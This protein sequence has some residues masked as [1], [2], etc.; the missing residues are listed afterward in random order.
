MFRLPGQLGKD[1]CDTHLGST[2]RD[3]LRIGGAGMM[4]MTLNNLFRA[5]AASTA[6]GAADAKEIAPG[7]AEV[8]VTQVFT[9]L[10]G[11]SEHGG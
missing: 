5:Q 7:A 2:R 8:G 11:K 1:L 10:S 6:S 3:F 4:G 9:E